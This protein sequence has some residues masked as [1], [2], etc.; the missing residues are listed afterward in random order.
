[1]DSLLPPFFITLFDGSCYQIIDSSIKEEMFSY[2]KML[3]MQCRKNR[4][5]TKLATTLTKNQN[6]SINTILQY[7]HMV[8]NRL[9]LQD[10]HI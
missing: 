2:L 4:V 6:D 3:S 7:G 9:L 8:K 10:F 1:M 5:K